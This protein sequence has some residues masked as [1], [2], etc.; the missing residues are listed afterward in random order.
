MREAPA[1]RRSPRSGPET[2][3]ARVEDEGSLLVALQHGHTVH[4]EQRPDD[5]DIADVGNVAQH[6]R[7]LPQQGAHH[8]LRREVLR[9]LDLDASCERPATADR[10]GLAGQL[11]IS[12]LRSSPSFE[13][14]PSLG[15]SSSG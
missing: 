13:R 14:A 8:R 15:V 3:P 1:W 2:A 10:E 4:F 12:H 6:A 9:T 7:R 11:L 5:L